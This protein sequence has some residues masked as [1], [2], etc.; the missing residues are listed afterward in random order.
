[1]STTTKTLSPT[2]TSTSPTSSTQPTTTTK[3]SPIPKPNDNDYNI[4]LKQYNKT[5]NNTATTKIS[6]TLLPDPTP[7]HAPALRAWTSLFGA[8][9]TR[10]HPDEATFAQTYSHPNGRLLIAST[11]EE[12]VAGLIAFRKY[13]GRFSRLPELTFLG[14]GG[15]GGG[16]SDPA[17]PNDHVGKR[18]GGVVEVVRLFVSPSHRNQGIATKLIRALIDLAREDG[19]GYMYLHTHPFL[20]GAERLWEKEGWRVLVRE[21]E[22]VWRSI[23]MG[24]GLV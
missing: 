4:P 20:P 9:T 7:A 23:H 15:I 24:R 19:V 17:A 8:K 13:D 2:S 10:P 21:E 14:G 16:D 1:M 6:I 22:G 3:T 5:N 11:P 12:P 18:M